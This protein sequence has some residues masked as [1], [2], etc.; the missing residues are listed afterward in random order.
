MTNFTV[1]IKETQQHASDANGKIYIINALI[2]IKEQGNQ[3][4]YTFKD[5]FYKVCVAANTIVKAIEI[6]P[7]II[8]IF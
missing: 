4:M 1:T 8:N 3:A 7:G 5:P 2:I 6:N